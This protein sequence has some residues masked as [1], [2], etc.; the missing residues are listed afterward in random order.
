MR[1]KSLLVLAMVGVFALAISGCAQDN[2]NTTDNNPEQSDGSAGSGATQSSSTD[3]SSATPAAGGAGSGST[4]VALD[5]DPSGQL[6]Y[7]TTKLAAKSGEVEVKFTNDSSIPHNV[8]V[9]DSSGKELGATKDLTKSKGTL[10]L[11]AVP[12]GSYTFFCSIPGH[13]AAGMK[14]TL[15]VR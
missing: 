11:K 9:E 13:E 15:T 7:N 10:D 1:L 8:T 6:K 12:A 2:T 5:A 14:G 4:T 3:T